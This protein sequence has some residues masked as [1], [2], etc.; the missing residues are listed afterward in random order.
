MPLRSW[1]WLPGVRHS[2]AGC[3][4]CQ[5]PGLMSRPCSHS[6]SPLQRFS[7][8]HPQSELTGNKWGLAVS[9]PGQPSFRT[10]KSQLYHQGQV[11]GIGGRCTHTGNVCHHSFCWSFMSACCPQCPAGSSG[12]VRLGLMDMG[13]G[14]GLA[15]GFLTWENSCSPSPTGPLEVWCGQRI[16]VDALE[17]VVGYFWQLHT[18]KL[19]CRGGGPPRGPPPS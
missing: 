11:R 13:V 3:L 2:C 12:S 1:P 15:L 5:S 8:P 17:R 6:C 19:P 18:W 14:A 10:L 9:Q 7:W 4:P 16:S